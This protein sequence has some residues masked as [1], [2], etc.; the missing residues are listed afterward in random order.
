MRLLPV[1]GLG[2]EPAATVEGAPRV[3]AGPLD[4]KVR[5]ELPLATEGQPSHLRCGGEVLDRQSPH[6]VG[7][8]SIL[9]DR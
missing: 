4:R 6:V 5:R 9:A 3:P 7:H 2:D 8:A 1:H